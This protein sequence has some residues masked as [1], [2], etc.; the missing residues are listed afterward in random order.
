MK[1]AVIWKHGGPEVLSYEEIKSPTLEKDHAIVKVSYCAINHLDIWVRNGL[2]GKSVSFPH[3]LGCDVCG[4][5][6]NGFGNFKKGDKVVV[7]P[8]VESGVPRV[9]YSIVGGFSKYQGGY[10]ELIQ[11]PKRNIVKKPNWLTDSEAS[12]LNVSYLTAW[13]M[14]ERSGCKKGDS[15]LIWGA[16]SGVGSAAI[17][18]AKAKGLKTIT[19]ASDKMKIDFAKKLGA[20]FVINRTDSDVALSVLKHT[21]NLGVDAV[22]DH[23]G[24]KTWPVSIEVLKVGGRMIACGTTTGGEASVNI[25]TFYSK[26]AQIIGAY[27]GSKSQLVAL[28]KFMKLKKIKPIIDSIF[29]LKD[30]ALAHKKMEQSTQLGKIVLK[31]TS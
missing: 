9:S 27:L 8:A 28:H 24:S 11:V 5:L 29:D 22:I 19:I 12:S 1:A 13:N 25:R 6:V 18:L 23:V 15:I 10:A 4:T 16:N 26:E 2:P 7:Y 17:L 20:N 31:V 21:D 14:L 3:I 30:V